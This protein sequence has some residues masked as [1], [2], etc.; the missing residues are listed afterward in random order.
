M[1]IM[2]QDARFRDAIPSLFQEL[3]RGG[4][5]EYCV[6][7]D[8][9]IALGDTEEVDFRLQYD[10]VLLRRYYGSSE[11]ECQEKRSGS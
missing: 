2:D 10:S 6:A 11:K 5:F 4:D 1:L 8:S 9:D 7:C 3:C